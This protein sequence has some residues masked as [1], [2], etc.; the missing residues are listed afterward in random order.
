MRTLFFLSMM[1]FSL[2]AFAKDDWFCERESA[3]RNGG[4]YNICGV[5]QSNDETYARSR[6]L[7]AAL[8]D[9]DKMCSESADCDGRPK[10]VEPGRTSCS[11]EA[12]GLW[13]CYRMITIT[14]LHKR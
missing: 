6:A 3:E 8:G 2:P 7:S 9:F 12:N 10:T 5:A 11:V 4:V 1:F 13:K 14:I